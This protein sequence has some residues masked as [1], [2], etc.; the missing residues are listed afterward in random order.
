MD[1]REAAQENQEEAEAPLTLTGLELEL[2]VYFIDDKSLDR[3]LRH[4]F[5]ESCFQRGFRERK[6]KN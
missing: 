3:L 4:P 1:Q 6:V 5:P 2:K